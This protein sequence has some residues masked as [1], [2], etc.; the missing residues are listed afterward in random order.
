MPPWEL[1][2]CENSTGSMVKGHGLS[3]LSPNTGLVPGRCLTLQS[4]T[5][6]RCSL[7]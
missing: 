1:L 4:S 6:N 3:V 5:R 2:V 7:S